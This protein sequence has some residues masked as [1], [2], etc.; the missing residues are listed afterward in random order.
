MFVEDP[1]HGV[2]QSPL[3]VF[4]AFKLIKG[5]STWL[6][7][8]TP[9]RFTRSFRLLA[10]EDDLSETCLFWLGPPKVLKTIT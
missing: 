5:I 2:L 9:L 6:S 3:R 1:A 4:V 8:I 10:V 7:L